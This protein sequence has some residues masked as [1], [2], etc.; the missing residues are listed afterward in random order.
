MTGP[1]RD[2]LKEL[3][4][5]EVF[6]AVGDNRVRAE[7]VD[8]SP[9]RF[10]TLIHPFSWVAPDVR[11]GAGSLVCAGV[12]IQPGASVGRQCIVNTSSSID[13]DCILEDFVHISPGAHLA[14][15][16]VVREGAH[17]GI[18]ATVIQTLEIGAW[19]VVG[20]G[21]A[22]VRSVPSNVVV[23]GVPAR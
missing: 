22:V 12:V 9:V 17:V 8:L 15:G 16:V 20:G 23:K 3:Q 10:A 1:V 2:R 4:D 18:G 19:S 6:L 21:A 11:I 13:H 7:L 14:G 5:V